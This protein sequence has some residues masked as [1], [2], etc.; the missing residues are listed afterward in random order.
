MMVHN[1]YMDRC[2]MTCICWQTNWCF[3]HKNIGRAA[4]ETQLFPRMELEQIKKIRKLE[5]SIIQT[6][7]SQNL[8]QIKS[9]HK[10]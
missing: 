1:F 3:S 6:S 5:Q 2:G 8:S 9:L 10:V 7:K 4:E